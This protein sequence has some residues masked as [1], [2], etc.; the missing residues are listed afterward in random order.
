MT[1]AE[2][3]RDVRPLRAGEI[4]GIA[5]A[6][7]AERMALA[8]V[9]ASPKHPGAAVARASPAHQL[10]THVGPDAV[11]CDT[12]ATIGRLGSTRHDRAAGIDTPGEWSDGHES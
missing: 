6:D 8:Y 5:R 11:F 12:G 4:A 3:A 1:T 9:A 10:E 7:A 2:T